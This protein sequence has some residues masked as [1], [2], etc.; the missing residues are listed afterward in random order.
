[1]FKTHKHFQW[2]YTQYQQVHDSTFSH[3]MFIEGIQLFSSYVIFHENII[4][5]T[6]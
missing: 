3:L 4:M 6:C 1:M 5:L 2:V